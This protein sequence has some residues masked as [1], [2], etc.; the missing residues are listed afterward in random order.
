MPSAATSSEVSGALLSRL[1]PR[2]LASVLTSSLFHGLRGASLCFGLFVLGNWIVAGMDGGIDSNLW[3]IDLR[4]LSFGLRSALLLAVAGA[5][6]LFALKPGIRGLPRHMIQAL[7]LGMCLLA[8]RDSASAMQLMGEGRIGAWNIPF[9][10]GVAAF[11]LGLVFCVA[12]LSDRQYIQASAT[13]ALHAQLK[14]KVRRRRLGK[15]VALTCGAALFLALF[16]MGIMATFGKADYSRYDTTT[17]NNVAVVFGAGV[18]MDGTPSLALSDRT[19]TAIRLYQEKRV[20]KLLFSGGPGPGATHE[21]EAMAKL[22][23][24]QGIPEAAF[25]FDREGLST[26]ATASNTARLQTKGILTAGNVFAVTH[27]YHL[28]RVELAF[29]MHGLDV[30]TVPATETRPLMRRH[31]YALREVAGFWAYWAARGVE[32]LGA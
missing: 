31:Y 7:F 16:P 19:M 12:K 23:R 1:E 29:Q 9:S 21:T 20:S 26:W 30:L 22:A 4:S 17:A 32:S 8:I 3:W 11:F 10:C 25:L 2:S 5:M 28:P 15:V 14:G 6:V 27:G 13:H 18:R 24:D